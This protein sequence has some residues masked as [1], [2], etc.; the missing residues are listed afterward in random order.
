VGVGAIVG[1]GVLVLAGTAFRA[2]GP[3]AILAFALNGAVAAVTAA[4]FAEMST[5]FPES[6]GAYVFAKK[7]LNVRAA[8]AVG[9]VLWFAYI[10]G[11]VLYAL[12][13]AEYARELVADLWRSSGHHV[14][15]WLESRRV[16]LVLAIAATAGYTLALLRKASGGGQWATMGKLAVFA[17]LL[18]VGL[19][20]MF[21][22]ND[23][24][25]MSRDLRPFFPHGAPGLLQAMGA[26]FIAVQGSSSSQPSLARCAIHGTR[27]PARCTCPSARRCSCTCLCC[28]SPRRPV[29]PSAPTSRSSASS[30]RKP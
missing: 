2:T 6:G 3:S 24:D 12:G 1:G 28:S 13:F 20:V 4:S 7:I 19:W 25:P 10:V 9:W 17:V 15:T 29:P 14:P 11:A 18:G 23:V 21:A 26:T 5:A 22:K 30:T 27:F 16:V 8:F